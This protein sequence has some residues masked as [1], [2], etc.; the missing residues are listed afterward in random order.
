MSFGY[1]NGAHEFSKDIWG[2]GPYTCN[3]DPC[4]AAV[5]GGSINKNTGGFYRTT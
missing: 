1:C 4:S 2:S 5:H 3:R